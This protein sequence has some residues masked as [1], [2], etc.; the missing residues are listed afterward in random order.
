MKKHYKALVNTDPDV[1]VTAVDCSGEV[2]K[3]CRTVLLHVDARST[4][5]AYDINFYDDSGAAAANLW[6]HAETNGGNDQWHGQLIVG[7]DTVRKFHYQA[8][9]ANVDNL[10]IYLIGYWE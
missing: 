9:H 7:L 2:S 1:A 6:G 5:G 3:G 10:I 4:G 8:A